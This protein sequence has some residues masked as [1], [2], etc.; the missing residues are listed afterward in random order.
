MRRRVVQALTGLVGGAL[1]L[2]G[3]VKVGDLARRH[4][5]DDFRYTIPFGDIECSPPAALGRDEFLDEVRYLADAPARLRLLD[6]DLA[7]RLAGAFARHP[8]VE[9]VESVEVR[10]RQ[11]RA[12]LAFRRPVLAVPHEGQL[13]AVDR[14]GVLLPA[15]AVTDGLPVYSGLAPPPC[16][17][18]GTPWGDEAVEEAARRAAGQGATLLPNR[19][20]N[21]SGL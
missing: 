16:G 10:A 15:A 3:T 17:P 2:A 13:R 5:R 6:D 4:L 19:S 12:R 21:S 11:V 9:R 1:V 8:W 18:A 14:N 20:T 7:G